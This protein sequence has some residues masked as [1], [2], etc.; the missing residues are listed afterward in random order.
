MGNSRV[1]RVLKVIS[2]GQMVTGHVPGDIVTEDQFHADTNVNWL[3]SQEA[4][5]EYDGVSAYESNA[6]PNYV[7]PEAEHQMMGLT[8]QGSEPPNEVLV[9]P[10]QEEIDAQDAEMSAGASDPEKVGIPVTKPEEPE[11]EAAGD[12]KDDTAVVTISDVAAAEK[13]KEPSE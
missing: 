1:F 2:I 10:T 5:V 9:T 11:A 12:D 3:I 7:S 4:I 8:L 13:A 6:D